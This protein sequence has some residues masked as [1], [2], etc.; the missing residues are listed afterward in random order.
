MTQDDT[1]LRYV[2]LYD[3][4]SKE[5]FY[6]KLTFVYIELVKFKQPLQHLSPADKW[7]YLLR[8][9]PELQQVPAELASEPFTKAFEIAEEAALSN[10]DRWVYEGSLKQARI[11]NAQLTAATEKGM[12]QGMAQGMAEGRRTEKIEIARSLRERGLSMREIMEVT[13]L[14]E[15]ELSDL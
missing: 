11:F 4:K 7:I 12:A 6:D 1:Y 13:G 8:H 2:R 15:A 5:V 9:L 10:E 14:T 3:T